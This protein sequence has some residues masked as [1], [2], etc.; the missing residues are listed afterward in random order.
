MRSIANHPIDSTTVY[1]RSTRTVYCTKMATTIGHSTSSS[2]LLLK[3]D[4][5]TVLLIEGWS[6]GPLLH[7][8]KGLRDAKQKYRILQPALPMPPFLGSWWWHRDF[9]AMAIGLLGIL[10]I[11]YRLMHRVSIST[12]YG[13]TARILCAFV[14]LASVVAWLRLMAAVAVRSSIQRGVEIC[15]KKMHEHNVVAI[16]AFSW[17]GAVLA[18]LLVQGQVGYDVTQPAALLIAPATASVA[19]VAMRKDAA[20]R[21][22]PVQHLVHVVHASND[23]QVCP[24]PERWESV[25]GVEYTMLSDIHIFQERASKRALVEILK[26]LMEQKTSLDSSSRD[27][28]NGDPPSRGKTTPSQRRPLAVLGEPLD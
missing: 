25:D 14:L 23:R 5:P 6:L 16:V 7:L 28:H 27:N 9:I 19:K 18:E 8:R 2:D 12:Y 21:I 15:L 3:E 11:G 1:S 13:G 22:E 4:D 10:R 20:L 24:H 26:R 17:G